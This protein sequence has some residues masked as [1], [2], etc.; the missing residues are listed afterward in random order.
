MYEEVRKAVLV[1]GISKREAARIY[2]INRRTVAKMCKYSTPPGYR[3]KKEKRYPKLGDYK[4]KIEEILKEDLEIGKKQRHTS[5]RIYERL[6]VEHGYNGSYDAVRRYISERKQV[7]KEV[8]IP[9]DHK[10][11]V[12]QCDF[13][14]CVGNIG[15]ID[16]KLHY[17]VMSLCKSG[18]I[19][20]KAYFAED[21][22][23]WFNGHVNGFEYFGGVPKEILYDNTSILVRKIR[24]YGERDLT[25][26]FSE[27]RSHYLFEALFT[28]PS[29]GN[30]KG[31]VE[32]RVGYV[33]RNYFVPKPK[34]KT[35]EELNDYL[36]KACELRRNQKHHKDSKTIGE[37]L[38]KEK[39]EFLTLPKY[40]YECCDIKL[41]KVNSY[42][43]VRYKTNDYSVPTKY[44]YKDVTLKAHYNK[45]VIFYKDRE[46]AEHL[47]CFGRYEQS[48]NYLHYLPILSQKSKALDQAR[49]L[50]DLKLPEEFERLRNFL[51]ERY[52]GSKGIREYIKIL[53]LLSH[54]SK[55]EIKWAI[56]KVFTIGA[57][58][59]DSIK[60]TLHQKG[61]VAIK[62]LDKNILTDIPMAV[63]HP[64]ALE[65]YDRMLINTQK[66]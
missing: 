55:D 1:N 9:L 53:E 64:P 2:G 59:I 60:Q 32:N 62:S 63:V 29:K 28:N 22:I 8:Y 36:K 52:E 12:A 6:K 13:G 4:E 3:R 31:I 41:A 50:Q 43:L 26:R 20:V 38:L 42:S 23:A 49:P 25:K 44:A 51:E 61:E 14:E 19:F 16:V 48:Y 21:Q 66:L 37:V 5:K 24:K 65:K 40:R 34:Y 33:R 15:G 56:T 46:I 54:H 17:I 45:V 30:E 18:D 47:R 7:E 35:I 11:G 57:I 39:E 27:L 10:Y 58:D